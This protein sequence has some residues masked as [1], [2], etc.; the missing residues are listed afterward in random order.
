MI[1]DIHIHDVKIQLLYRDIVMH[2]SGIQNQ[3]KPSL[4]HHC[5]RGAH[6]AASLCTASIN[7]L[8]LLL[9]IASQQQVPFFFFLAT[10]TSR[11]FGL[12]SS[13][14]VGATATG[15]GATTVGAA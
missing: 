5:G 1:S 9:S 6:R 13:T 11:V 3:L 14:T 15:A 10:F 2:Y 8:R 7:R 12:T 4:G